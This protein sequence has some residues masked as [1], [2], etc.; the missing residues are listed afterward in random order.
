MR[1]IIIALLTAQFAG[2]RK[3]VLNSL[4]RSLALQV[5]NEDEAKALVGKLTREQVEGYGR[6]YRA[7]VDKEVSESTRTFEANF[8][9]KYNIADGK[10]EPGGGDGGSKG[11]GEGA[12]DIQQLIKAAVSEA[13]K[14]MQETIAGYEADKVGKARLQALT[15]KLAS[16]KDETFKAQAV[17]DFKR[18]QFESDDAFTEYLTE[19]ETDI[20]A[21]NQAMADAALTG[22]GKPMFGGK[23][24]KTGVSSAVAAYVQ[25]QTKTD[26]K[27]TGNEV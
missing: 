23:D 27:F 6:E 21:A 9:K 2:V 10:T 3:D 26:D 7:E 4:A 19:K 12:D 22:Q 8:R 1:E 15:E 16:C 24:E 20:A 17:K 14:P 11:K 18:M 25:S 5:S 13:L